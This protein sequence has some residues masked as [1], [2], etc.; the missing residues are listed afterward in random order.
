MLKRASSAKALVV[1][2]VV[3]A[4]VPALAT[5]EA[6]RELHEEGIR[7]YRIGE[8]PDAIARFSEAEKA[9]PTY[10]YP[11]FALA[12]IYDDL[13]D[14]AHR[15]YAAAAEYYERLAQL[16]EADPPPARERALYQTHYYRGLLR[17]KGGEPAR[18]LES[19]NRFLEVYPDF[20][21][22]APVHN[23]RGVAL[24]SLQDYD[25][26]AGA[27]RAALR[28]DPE[29]L[30]ARVNL[31]SVFTRLTLYREAL[32][33]TRAGS[34]DE[35]LERVAALRRAAPAYLRGQ[36]LEASIR[37]KMGQD[38][39]ALAIFRDIL[40]VR[41]ADPITHDVRLDAARILEAKGQ[42]NEALAL[43]NEDLRWFRD[44]DQARTQTM[45]EIVRLVNLLKGSP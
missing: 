34:L 20:H 9:D 1:V 37:R 13:F 33:N 32:A 42:R 5:R 35:A 3:L 31:Q 30:E 17:L 27:F 36:Y 16:L 24:Y 39:E 11:V 10:P 25:A 23:A 40:A 2:L 43:L 14:T 21:S 26:A 6:A 19:L 18:A 28:A 8:L 29:S 44:Q 7:L 12:R 41:P 22:L 38:E 45:R 15:H 4:A